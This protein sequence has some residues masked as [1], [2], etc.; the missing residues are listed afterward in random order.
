MAFGGVAIGII[1][2][3]L[4]AR[5]TGTVKDTGNIPRPIATA[6]NTGKN[7]DVVATL[8]VISVRNIIKA[9]TR[10]ISIIG[11]TVPKI[12][13]PSPIHTPKPVEF[14]CAAMDKPP[15]NNIKRP[16]GNLFE[17]S[18]FNKSSLLFDEGIINNNIAEIIAIPASVS[19]DNNSKL[20]RPFLN[21][22]ANAVKPNITDIFNSSFDR[23]PKSSSI[24]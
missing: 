16:Q 3:Q 9:A 7:V 6:P 12:L 23:G 5:H 22:H 17:L 18:Q 13:K 15:P 4:A 11:G 2:A 20:S 1:K 19:P 14:I 21:I 10:N 24:L 8:L